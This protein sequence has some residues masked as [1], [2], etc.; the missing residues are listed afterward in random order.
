MTC[1]GWS[2]SCNK[3]IFWRWKRCKY[4]QFSPDSWY[5]CSG[6]SSRR[7]YT[8]SRFYRIQEILFQFECSCFSQPP[9]ILNHCSEGSTFRKF[10]MYPSELLIILLLC[11]RISFLVQPN[12]IA[13]ISVDLRR[14]AYPSTWCL[15]NDLRWSH[16]VGVY[17][18]VVI[19]VD[20]ET[21][22]FT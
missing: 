16:A 20:L 9:S 6:V 4:L 17:N 18:K 11:L 5:R 10:L 8:G 19:H 21:N 22:I 14:T 7:P 12:N 1:R 13:S 15:W 3:L 2:S